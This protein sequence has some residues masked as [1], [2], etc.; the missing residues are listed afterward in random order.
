[1]KYG[2]AR[3][4]FF[5]SLFVFASCANQVNPTGGKKDIVPPKAEQFVPENYSTNFNGKDIRIS[6][7]EYI[8]MKDVSTQLVVS[9]PLKYQPEA[10]VR[11]KTLL[12]HLD[13]TLLE[14]TTYTLNF[15]NAIADI[16]EG[17]AVENFQYVFSTGN[18]IDSLSIS[19][20]VENAFDNKVNKGV[21][22]MLYRTKEDSIPMKQLPNYFSKTDSV[23]QFKIRN[24]SEGS[25]KIVAL[26]DT[27]SNYLFDN[28]DEAIAFSDSSVHSEQTGI[29]LRLFKETPKLRLVGAHSEEP[30]KVVLV[31]NQSLGDAA[32]EIKTDTS[33]L[34]LFAKSVSDKKDSVTIW[35]RNRLSD[36]LNVIV[37]R[38]IQ[39]DTIS[40][41]LK[42]SDEKG[43]FRYTPSLTTNVPPATE[44]SLDLNQPLKMIFN[45]PVEN[46]NWSN[47]ILTEDS[48]PVKNYSASFSDSLKQHLVINY[49]WKESK[50]YVLLFPPSTFT[51]IFGIKNDT[52]Q[53]SFKSK[54][55]ADYGTLVINLQVGATGPHYLLQL[56]DEKEII[57]RQ[58]ALTED[59]VIHYEYLVPKFYRLKLVEDRNN[60]G[61]WDTGN[62]LKHVQ[63]ERV[64]YYKDDIIVRANWD[65]DVKWPVDIKD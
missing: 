9:P 50:K 62:Y 6:F 13:D 32:V 56:I 36:S 10:K 20:K 31:Y 41:R 42:R 34:Q 48:I 40:L 51:D 4:I 38:A 53:Y 15:G 55:L 60:N 58:S 57:Y 61:E 49:P 43:K 17:N 21:N 46:S 65:V 29:H 26:R 5:V 39:N 24:L 23:G 47:I 64:F 14:N 11:S 25:Y 16:T 1:M 54:E 22:V 63:A 2:T 12:I 44:N 18:V 52:L 19:G 59:T 35:Y 45:H 28:A 30:G 3:L 37:R 27:N 33:I 8:Q 7:N